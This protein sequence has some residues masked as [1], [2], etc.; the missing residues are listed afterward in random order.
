MALGASER[1]QKRVA[2]EK[3]LFVAVGDD[4]ERDCWDGGGGQWDG[5]RTSGQKR[6]EWGD[7]KRNSL[8]E[9]TLASLGYL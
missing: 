4:E 1:A 9:T 2:C 7:Q 5:W 6:R 3:G 8:V